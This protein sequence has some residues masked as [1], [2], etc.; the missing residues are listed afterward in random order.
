[1]TGNMVIRFL[2]VAYACVFMSLLAMS[3]LRAE[4]EEDGRL[5]ASIY[6]QGKLPIDQLYW[7]MDTHPRWR[8]EGRQFDQLILRPA[9]FYRLDAARSVWLG[10]DT[11]FN[12]PQ[13]QPMFREQRL[14]QQ[15]Q[16]QF[17]PVADISFTSRTRLEQRKREDAA[18]IGHRLRQMVRAS[19]PSGWQPKLAWVVFD[20]VFIQLNDTDW[21]A[22]SGLDQNR[23][24][25]GINWQF[26]AQTN[27]DIGY[28]NQWVNQRNTDRENHVLMSTVRFNF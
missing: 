12:H 15:F 27:M 24:F 21:G 5:W 6:L 22:R 4:T 10:F 18:E 23:L 17:A 20:E 16:W 28:L 26:D 8:E 7:S 3:G 11:V 14:W 1:M 19:L 25:L 2:R 9:L 13:G